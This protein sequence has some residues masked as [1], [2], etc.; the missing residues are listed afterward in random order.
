IPETPPI[1]RPPSFRSRP[2]TIPCWPEAAPP[3]PRLHFLQLLSVARVRVAVGLFRHGHAPCCL[4]EPLH[5]RARRGEYERGRPMKTKPEIDVL[6]EL[7]DAAVP[8]GVDRR[9]FMMRSA[10]VGAVA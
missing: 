4:R 8:A 10:M 6:P 9:A 7:A 1:S 5:T 3:P 2:V